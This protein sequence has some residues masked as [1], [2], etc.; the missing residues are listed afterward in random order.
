MSEDEEDVE[1][2]E[3]DMSEDEAFTYKN[4]IRK[5][6]FLRSRSNSKE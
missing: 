5:G 2:D 1:D 3:D 6:K 4:K